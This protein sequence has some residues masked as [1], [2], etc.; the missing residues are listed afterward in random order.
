MRNKNCVW[1]NLAIVRVLIHLFFCTMILKICAQV[2]L[3]APS[4][5]IGVSSKY[6]NEATAVKHAQLKRY[7]KYVC[8]GILEIP[9]LLML[10]YLLRNAVTC[11][12]RGLVLWL[13]LLALVCAEDIVRWGVWLGRNIC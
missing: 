2:Q 3:I 10:F 5:Y 6:L 8:S 1:N 11:S 13:W 4:A 12:L 9:L 7:C